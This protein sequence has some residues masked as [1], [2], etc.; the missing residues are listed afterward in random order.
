MA[1]FAAAGEVTSIEMA[2]VRLGTRAVRNAVLAACLSSWGQTVDA[3]GRRGTD[4]IQHAVG[5]ACIARRVAERL[6]LLSDDAFVHGLLHDVGK[7]FLLKMR[8][9][10]LRIGGRAPA[11]EEFES[12]LLEQHADVGATAL[13]LWRLPDSVRSA[14]R[15]HQE[16]LNAADDPRAASI[17]YLA[18]R[19]SH[20]YGFGCPPADDRDGIMADAICTS[21][22]LP[23]GW[24][25]KLD[26][27]ALALSVSARHL[28]S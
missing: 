10:Y 16:P 27:E 24:L 15:W 5:T 21:L 23:D 22:G 9:E 12:V 13:Q 25:D 28:V 20:R 14:V 4:E 3:Y 17:A 8:S 7:L 11:P 1:A 2:V 18:N 19:L 6:R 26:Q